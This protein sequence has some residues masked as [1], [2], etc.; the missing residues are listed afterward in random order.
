MEEGREGRKQEEKEEDS[1]KKKY[2]RY[3]LPAYTR[4]Y[5]GSMQHSVFQSDFYCF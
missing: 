2:T 3:I 4:S 1:K 5:A